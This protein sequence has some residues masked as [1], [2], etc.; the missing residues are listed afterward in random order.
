MLTVIPMSLLG[1][2]AYSQYAASIEEQVG[3]YI[4][5]LLDQ[6]N[7]NI[8]N[9][10]Y[11]IKRL[12]DLLYNSSQVIS[13]LRKDPY[14]IR[15][16]TLQDEFTVNNYLSRTYINGANPHILGVFI[17]SNN[18]VYQSVKVP[19]YDF[20][21][22]SLPYGENFE[23]KGNEEMIILP[24]QTTLHFEG[25]PPY[26][27][28][29]RQLTDFE[30]RKNLGTMLIAIDSKFLEGVINKLNLN[31]YSHADLWMM[32]Q[33]GRI[34]YHTNPEYIGKVDEEIHQYPKINGSF[35]AMTDHE[36]SLISTNHLESQEWILV[37]RILAK[38]LMGRADIVRNV[39]IIAFVIFVMISTAISILVAWQVSKPLNRLA[40]QMERVE[41]GTFDVVHSD[42]GKDEV[43]MLTNRFNSMVLEIKHL[44]KEKYEI[45]LKQKE[46]EL[47]ALQSQINPHFMYNT[48]ETI[49]MAVED[50]EKETVVRMVTL[51]GRMLRYSIN[52]KDLLVPV[53][54]E[55]VHMKDYL[56]IQKIRF[57]DK[58][59]FVVNEEFNTKKYYT[60]KFLLQPIVENVVKH[61]MVYGKVT[62]IE[63]SVKIVPNINT[64]VE[65]VVFQIKDNG[66][67][68]REDILEKIQTS[69]NSDPM[70]K[71]DS[72]FGLINVHARIAMNF[73]LNYGLQ[74]NSE[75]GEGTQVEVRIPVIAEEGIHDWKKD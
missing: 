75:I 32:D 19:Y 64:G 41:K 3:E 58:L 40:R 7:V 68:T 70:A 8:S 27:L 72:Q 15:S 54:N 25:K 4:P 31:S 43:G 37:H 6:A 65:E 69:L 29:M 73:G 14:D 13:I 47:Y 57:E 42:S 20:G 59:D 46:A 39:T 60:P 21:Y 30:N 11:E 34:I 48:L 28:L 1:Y 26:I 24:H 67:G 61:G 10:L 12:P 63:T 56:T 36:T 45:E 38:D 74:V 9:Q 52:N 2:I 62:T 18:R 17:L 49:A 16:K 22:E 66:P 71:R 44:I 53:H 5:K 33:S 51:L 50:D 23:L 35:R 55:L